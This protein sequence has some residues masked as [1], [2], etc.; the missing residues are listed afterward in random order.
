MKGYLLFL[1]QVNHGVGVDPYGCISLLGDG[2][3]L[4]NSFVVHTFHH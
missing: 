2:I 3:S 4:F 1:Q